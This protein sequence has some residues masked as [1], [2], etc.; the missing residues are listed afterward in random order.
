MSV[1]NEQVRVGAGARRDLLDLGELAHGADQ[2]GPVQP[3]DLAGVRGGERLGALPG[4]V[5]QRVDG[6]LRVVG[7]RVGDQIAEI[8]ADLLELGIGEGFRGGHSPT[9]Y[10]VGKAPEAFVARSPSITIAR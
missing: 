9:A 1:E 10:E 5:E 3:R 4:V 2:T 6:G 7:P 8:P